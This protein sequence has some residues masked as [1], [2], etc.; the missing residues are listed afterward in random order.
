MGKSKISLTKEELIAAY[1]SW[2]DAYKSDP[3]GSVDY[4]AEGYDDSKYAVDSADT[5]LKH[6]AKVQGE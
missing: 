1:Q 6:L 3:E 4:D 5:F 2:F